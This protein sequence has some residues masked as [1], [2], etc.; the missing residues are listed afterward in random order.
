MAKKKSFSISNFS[1]GVE[2][3][4]MATLEK[5]R[6]R[7]KETRKLEM[8]SCKSANNDMGEETA[9]GSNLAGH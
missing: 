1:H 3:K 4:G 7:D 2:E 5:E 6:E 8:K 9:W